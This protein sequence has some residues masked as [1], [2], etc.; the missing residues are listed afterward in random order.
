MHPKEK[1]R[2]MLS[3]FTSQKNA[4]LAIQEE[5][6]I[7]HAMVQEKEVQHPGIGDDFNFNLIKRYFSP[8]G[9]KAASCA[10]NTFSKNKS[11][12]YSCNGCFKT[13]DVKEET[14]IQCDRC[15]HWYHISCVLL[16]KAKQNIGFAVTAE[17]AIKSM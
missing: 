4:D 15:L 8:S 16:K 9:W 7:S 3:W 2:E 12:R 10:I 6:L 13:F 17:E 5:C 11:S 14:S 1:E